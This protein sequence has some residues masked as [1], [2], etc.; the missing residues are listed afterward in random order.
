MPIVDALNLKNAHFSMP[1]SVGLIGLRRQKHM[2]E[3]TSLPTR[4]LIS[5]TEQF[6]GLEG[7]LL[8]GLCIYRRLTMLTISA[9]RLLRDFVRFIE[10]AHPFLVFALS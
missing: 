3:P 6:A 5:K 8:G 1:T 9:L 7:S 4:Y 2:F 10:Q